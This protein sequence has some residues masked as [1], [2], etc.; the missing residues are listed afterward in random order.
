[1]SKDA[2]LISLCMIAGN[3]HEHVRRCLKTFSPCADEIV[4]VRAIGS[5]QPDDTLDIAA[6][7]FGA[8]TSEYVNAPGHESW[9]HVDN[10]AAARNK[11]FDL[12][13]G[14]YLFWVDFDD[15]AAPEHVEAIKQ[16]ALDREAGKYDWDILHFG[17]TIPYSGA[18]PMRER[19]VVR[20]AGR[21]QNAVHECITDLK[22][23]CKQAI[24]EQLEI[25]H[26]PLTNK[27]KQGI[28]SRRNLTILESIKNKTHG[29]AF[30]Y[31]MELAGSGRKG[32]ALEAAKVALAMPEL[33]EPE[34]Y[35]IYM[36]L[37][38]M[39]EGKKPRRDF[40]WE[41]VKLSPERREALALLCAEATNWHEPEAA[42]SIGRMMRALP[43]P[44]IRNYT[45]RDNVYAYGGD[46]VYAGALRLNGHF[47]EADMM[48]TLNFVR[49]GAKISLLHATRGRPH[50]AALARKYWYDTAGNP[51]SIE[52]IFAI[53]EDDK[54]S[55]NALGTFRHVRVKAG[56]GCVAA[57]NAAAAV[58][59]GKVLI[60]LSDDWIPPI[61]WDTEILNRIGD[62]EKP[63][64]LAISDG[65][66]KDGLLCMAIL[67]RARYEQQKIVQFETTAPGPDWAAPSAL[68]KHVGCYLFHPDFKSMYSD[69]YFTRRAYGDGV[70][71]EAR[72]FVIEH[73]HPVFNSATKM[74]K[75]YAESNA[76][77]R[78][79]EG[80]ATYERLTGEKLP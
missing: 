3:E 75:T 16:A 70:V 72:D 20:G 79:A 57:W 69:N 44:T 2:P 34:K 9:P 68:K 71:I 7:E 27:V 62:L 25:V 22:P 76:P 49:A 28:S 19:L 36:N 67:T 4:V 63:A 17:Y 45:H 29:E 11:A 54:E 52:H 21:W 38:S 12:A 41:A 59:K 55:I 14:R 10:F 74:D 31:F 65:H 15:V 51:A 26:A 80:K 40:L 33:K 47:Q 43:R 6:K 60:Q 73:N 24:N 53:D 78:Y 23:G 77:E 46:M 39:A 1:M 8:V 66:R 50:A 37:A 42:L 13:T 64:V 5:L 18:K 32:E 61:C 35:E 48:E 58:S 30:F 56:G